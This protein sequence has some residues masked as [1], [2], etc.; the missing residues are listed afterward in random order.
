MKFY[1][2]IQDAKAAGLT[3][4]GK[5]FGVPAWMRCDGDNMAAVPKFQPFTAWTW[6]ADKAFDIASYFIP[7]GASLPSPIYLGSSITNILRA[8]GA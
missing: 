5:L 7:A 4:E 1:V 3:H 8:R 6:L 2:T